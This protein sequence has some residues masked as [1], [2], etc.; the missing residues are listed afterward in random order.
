MHTMTVTLRTVTPLF[1]GSASPQMCELRPPS[2]KGTLRFWFRFAEGA[3]QGGDVK[4]VKAEEDRL[5][6]SSESGAGVFRL[7][8]TDL[9]PK[10]TELRQVPESY[11]EWPIEIMYMGYGCIALRK[12]GR[13]R[14]EAEREKERRRAAGLLTT[15][16]EPCRSFIDAGELLTF[17]IMFNREVQPGDDQRIYHALWLWTHLGGFGSRSRR[18]WG[19]LVL[20]DPVLN[21]LPSPVSG[22]TKDEV[23]KSIA[24]GIA[25]IM[26]NS[27]LP[28][29]A[30]Y[31]HWFGDARMICPFVGSSWEEAM[32]WIGNRLI[33]YRS[34]FSRK[35]FGPQGMKKY[36]CWDD[37]EL[38]LKYLKPPPEH[39]D[40][41]A[42]PQRALFGL[43]QNY[44]FSERSL[45]K[46][47]N[48]G[49]V[50]ATFK[51]EHGQDA[52]IDRRSS[53]LLVHFHPITG[54]VAVLVTF[55]PSQFLPS[56][57]Q[58]TFAHDFDDTAPY[59]PVPISVPFPSSNDWTPISKFLQEAL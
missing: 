8:L 12:F 5:F 37:H 52:A 21:L 33:A 34:N 26:G 48:K 23:Q 22:R 49:R 50:T 17:R 29:K 53:P 20:Q 57:S 9:L 32:I 10:V 24:A 25:S 36:P 35:R 2:I 38:L 56:Q 4:A 18:G 6:G 7:T 54:G 59:A 46:G 28:A 31:T 42:P 43:P 1:L 39:R 40:P 13:N 55:V 51:N 47:Q 45:P 41:E 11:R 19:S 14:D 27:N 15:V 16:F 3:R 44:T 58:I 30:E